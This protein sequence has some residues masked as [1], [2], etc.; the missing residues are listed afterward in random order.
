MSTQPVA[1]PNWQPLGELNF[2]PGPCPICRSPD[3]D[4]LYK[5]TIA[6]FNMEFWRC[7]A[8][9]VLYARNRATIESLRR[10]FSS[11]DFFAAGQ[12][13]D[14]NIDYFDFIGGEK[15]LRMTA[16]DRISRIKRYKPSGRL[17]EVASAAGFFLIEAKEAGY[18][19]TGVEFSEPMAKYASE[20]WQVPVIP[21]SIELIDLPEH[22]FDLIASWGVLT[23][24][25]DPVAVFRKFYRALKPGGI[26]AFNTYYHDC[27]WHRLVTARWGILGVQT[28]QIFS[29]RLIIETIER[30]GFTL[31]SRRRDMPHSDLLKIAD[32]LAVNIGWRQLPKI[33]QNIGLA[34]L[35]V[36][37]PLPDVSEYIW[38]KG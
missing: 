32:Q 25:K 35:V 31:L 2:V 22:S 33:L 24:I 10:I 27:L 20:R 17:L 29:R 6:G 36:R 19:V 14:D 30:E 1:A 15:Y 11:K 8:C 13:G 16:T 34:N 23:I 3:G 38:I 18:D 21:E 12:P 7:T 4:A 5:K 26:W 37:I 28:S 9:D